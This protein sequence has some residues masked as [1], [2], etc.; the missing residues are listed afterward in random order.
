MVITN[1]PI[2]LHGKSNLISQGKDLFVE[3]HY[4]SKIG[5]H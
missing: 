1:C 4:K 3:P 2:D 5:L